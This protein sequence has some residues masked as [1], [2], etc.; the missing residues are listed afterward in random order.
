MT[1]GCGRV[2]GGLEQLGCG[3]T[4][5]IVT[6]TVRVT[7]EDGTSSRYVLT[8]E[9]EDGSVLLGPDTSYEAIA[10]PAPGRP[11]AGREFAKLIAPHVLA[12]DGEGEMP[13]LTLP[14]GSVAAAFDEDLPHAAWTEQ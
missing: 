4:V 13:A 9:R 2:R 1:D 8:E 7:R 5:K 3:A 12:P 11:L 6:P 14:V 10:E